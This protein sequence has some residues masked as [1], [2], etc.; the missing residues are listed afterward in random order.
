MYI[1][2]NSGQY[3][4]YIGDIKLAYPDFNDGDELPAGVFEVIETEMPASTW[5][6]VVTLNPEPYFVEGKYYTVWDVMTLTPEQVEQR[7]LDEAK[8]RVFAAGLS[9]DDILRV[10]ASLQ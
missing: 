8:M 3:P 4:L 6:N 2:T 10:A 5:E 1:D 7:K 9:N